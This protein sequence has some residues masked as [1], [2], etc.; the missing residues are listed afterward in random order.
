MLPINTS[1][2]K[3]TWSWSVCFDLDCV[4]DKTR[5]SLTKLKT[6]MVYATREGPDVSGYLV[7]QDKFSLCL[8]GE[9]REGELGPSR[10]LLNVHGEYEREEIEISLIGCVEEE[11]IEGYLVGVFA[12]DNAVFSGSFGGSNI[13]RQEA[14]P[15]EGCG[16]LLWTQYL[17]MRLA[18]RLTHV[19]IIRYQRCVKV[20]YL[21][22]QLGPQ[23]PPSVVTL[24][25]DLG[26]SLGDNKWVLV[27]DGKEENSPKVGSDGNPI[28]GTFGEIK[29]IAVQ[30]C[31]QTKTVQFIHQTL[32]IIRHGQTPTS[33]EVVPWT[34]E[35]HVPFSAPVVPP[36]LT[37]EG[38]KFDIPNVNMD[39]V[40]TGFSPQP[41]GTIVVIQF[42]FET[43]VCCD[44]QLAGYVSWGYSNTF[45]VGS[46]NVHSKTVVTLTKPTWVAHDPSN[47]SPR[48]GQVNCS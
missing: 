13:L 15:Q 33:S 11:R 19:R 25:E 3:T 30:G 2:A 10:L 1:T 6:G 26:K 23:N 28:S 41:A 46:N 5:Y 14:Q 35:P 40:Q 18:R 8:T 43:F 21:D 29:Y 45:V 27:Y 42:E 48:A 7:L 47:P 36:F 38:V 17:Q 22:P 32:T 12:S 34:L 24:S 37:D 31:Q 9:I 39:A 20:E 16:Y 4:G 44:G